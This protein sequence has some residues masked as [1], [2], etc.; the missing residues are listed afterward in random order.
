MWRTQAPL[1]AVSFAWSVVLGKILTLDNLRKRL[2][3]L[4][5]LRGVENGVCLPFLDYLEGEK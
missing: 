3:G 5:V 2:E 4:G 1:R